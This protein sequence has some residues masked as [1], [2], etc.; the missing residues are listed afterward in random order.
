MRILD[1]TVELLIART[2]MGD[3][4]AEGFRDAG[5]AL[6]SMPLPT[7]DFRSANRHLQNAICYCQKEE[8]GA[9]AFELRALRGQLQ[10]L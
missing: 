9:A 5:N 6:A 8:F 10:R 2:S 7:T 1:L 3:Y 4:W